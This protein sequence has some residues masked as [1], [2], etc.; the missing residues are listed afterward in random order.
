MYIVRKKLEIAG[1][2]NLH[3]DY[4]SPC[5]NLHGHNWIIY[6]WCRSKKLN[7][8]MV[9]DFSEI[10]RLI[11]NRLDHSYLND[12]FYFNP[13]A[14][15]ISKWICDEVPNCFKV[16]IYESENNYCCYEN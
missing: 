16:E 14:E 9:I 1:S 10:K 13:T 4:D 11:H 7:K 6:I 15:N 12:V 5:K 2:H 8:D 3:L